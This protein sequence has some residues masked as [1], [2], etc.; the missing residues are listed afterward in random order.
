MHG[1]AAEV[2]QEVIVLFQDDNVDPGAGKEEGVN[3]A[4]GTATGD[5]D[6]GLKNSRHG[7]TLLAES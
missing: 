5:T 6:L 3:H 7:L 1:V 2:A 4:G